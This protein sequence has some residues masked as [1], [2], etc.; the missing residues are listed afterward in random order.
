M[1]DKNYHS[2][3]AERVGQRTL[4]DLVP[5]DDSYSDTLKFGGFSFDGEV[6]AGRI[7]GGREDCVD[8]NNVRDIHVR[9]EVFE[10]RGRFLATIKGGSTDC[11]LSGTVVGHGTETDVD[12]GNWSDQSKEV[13]RGTCLCLIS[14]DGSPIRVRVLL[15]EWPVILNASQQN[16]RFALVSY[17]PLWMKRV[18]FWCWG[19]FKS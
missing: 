1:S 3:Y 7:V 6:V 11:E 18:G 5:P 8:M 16:Y 4:G 12:L 14:T 19:L 9:A 10:P 17:L 13:T 15:A 2:I